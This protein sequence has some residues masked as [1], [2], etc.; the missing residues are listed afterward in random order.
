MNAETY[1]F[2]SVLF[3]YVANFINWIEFQ[4]CQDRRC[5][6]VHQILKL[7]STDTKTRAINPFVVLITMCNG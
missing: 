1:C 5:P 2:F 4:V 7:I 3:V 6:T